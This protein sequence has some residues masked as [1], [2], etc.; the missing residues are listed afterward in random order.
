MNLDYLK[1]FVTI[2][3]KSGLSAAGRE[4]GL[5]AATVSE[6]LT[7]IESY[8][9]ASLLVRST[10]SIRLTEEGQLLLDGARR[11]LAQAEELQG[12]IRGGASSISGLIRLSAPVDLGRSLLLPII[13]RFLDEH[14]QVSIDIHLSDSVVDLVA[15]GIDFA[16]RYGSLTDSSLKARRLRDNRHVI[17]AAPAYLQRHGTPTTPDALASHD[18]ILMRFGANIERSWSFRVGDDLQRFGVRGRR[19]ANSGD[20]ARLWC[21]G[22][23]GIARKSFCDVRADLE[24]GRLVELLARFAAP[25]NSLQIVYPSS[26]AQPHRVRALIE[27]IA[28]RLPC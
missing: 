11:L 24:E 3:E 26:H 19:I 21:L 15:T 13:D 10:R 8:Y 9:G 27:F 6:R 20:I 22:G 2:V 23:H 1:L 16:V 7:A 18:C 14:P 4:M 25:P 12:S 5:S 28:T 17:C